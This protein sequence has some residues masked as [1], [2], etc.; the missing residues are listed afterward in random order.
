MRMIRNSGLDDLSS[1]GLF[2]DTFWLFPG[3]GV[4]ILNEGHWFWV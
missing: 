2:V 4:N 3:E 1:F